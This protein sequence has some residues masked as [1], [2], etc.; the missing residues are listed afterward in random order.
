MTLLRYNVDSTESF[1]AQIRLFAREKKY[2][3]YVPLTLKRI[4]NVVARRESL[5]LWDDFIFRRKASMVLKC[6]SGNG[7]DY[8]KQPILLRKH[9]REHS[10]YR[11]SLAAHL[12]EFVE[13]EKYTDSLYLDPAE[14]E[15]EACMRLEMRAESQRLRS[16][17]W[18]DSFTADVV[19]KFFPRT[20]YVK[21]KQHDRRERGLVKN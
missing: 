10:S 5:M 20:C 19:E 15:L 14:K 1:Y 17:D 4:F 18:V 12:K 3:K 8:T 16:I 2:Q 11:R 13:L 9:I 6:G 7:G 21:H